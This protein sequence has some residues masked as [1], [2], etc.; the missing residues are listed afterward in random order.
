M[1]TLIAAL[2]QLELKP[3]L[4]G[5]IN[6]DKLSQYSRLVAHMKADIQLPQPL[7]ESLPNVPPKFLSPS[8]VQFLA[9]ALSLTTPSVQAS[10]NILRIY[11]WQCQVVPLIQEDYNAFKCF[12]WQIGFSGSLTLT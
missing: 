10:W 7:D 4:H 11:L 8:I 2:Q 5:L 9:G 3:E 12:G 1:S 6:L